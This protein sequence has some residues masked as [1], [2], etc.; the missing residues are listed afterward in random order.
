MSNNIKCSC[1]Q[2]KQVISTSNIDK[3]YNSK[4]CKSVSTGKAKQFISGSLVCP[5]CSLEHIS[6]NAMCQHAIRCKLNPKRKLNPSSIGGNKYHRPAWNKGLTKETDERIANSSKTYSDNIKSGKTKNPG[7]NKHTEESLKKL[8]A[9]A[10]ARG[11]GG[12]RQSK[13]IEYNGVLLGS[14]YELELA[15][16][17]D[18]NGI[19]WELPKRLFYIDPFG[20][21]RS[22][23]ADFFLTD[24]DIYLDPKN[25]FLINSINPALGFKDSTKIELVEQ[26]N[27]VKVFILNKNQLNWET[28]S[29]LINS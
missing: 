6:H 13:K 17:L 5:F 28:V 29:K 21:R 1:A 22:Y 27:Q 26:Q 10:I 12:V 8:S 7:G 3:H 14:S 23:T 19:K 25:D 18:A 24:L 4:S 11:L 20:K 16:S 15:K 9:S 2:C